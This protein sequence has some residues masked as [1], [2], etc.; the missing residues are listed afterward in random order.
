MEIE[1]K[2]VYFSSDNNKLKPGAY[3]DILEGSYLYQM[4]AQERGWG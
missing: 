1:N 4:K 3:L 2:E